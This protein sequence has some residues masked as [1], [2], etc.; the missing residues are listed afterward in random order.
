MLV[1]VDADDTQALNFA[2]LEDLLG[3]LDAMLGNLGDVDQALNVTLQAG[4]GTEFGQAGNDTFNQLP[5][6]ILLDSGAPGIFLQGTHGETDAL[7]LAIDVDDLDLDFLAH[8]QHFTWMVDMLPRK[9][10]KMHKPIGTI[11]VDERA[12]VGEAGDTP[13]VHLAFLE[14]LD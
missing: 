11:N 1:R 8:F 10:G 5:H 9:L 4:K 14:L 3:M 6:T 7:L 13:G 12:K 2:F